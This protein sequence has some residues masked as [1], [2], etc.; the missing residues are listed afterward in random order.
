MMPYVSEAQRKYF[1]ANK[2]KLG[3]KMVEHW[4]KETKGKKLPQR[5]KKSK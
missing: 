1:N 5:V 2:K 4:N 3:T